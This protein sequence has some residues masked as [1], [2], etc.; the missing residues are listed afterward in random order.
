V[1]LGRDGDVDALGRSR[2]EEAVLMGADALALA[3]ITLAAAV[4]NG[5][6]GYGFSSIT[7]PIALLLFSNGVLNPALVSIEVALNA[8]VLWVNR[9]TVSQVV[10]RVGPIVIGLAPGIA[11]GALLVAAVDPTPLKGATYPHC[12]L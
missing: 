9:D 8:Y 1:P 6:L 4:V 11:A 12:C 10:C 2:H 5:G 3:V 7:V